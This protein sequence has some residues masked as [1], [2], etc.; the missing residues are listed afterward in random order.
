MMTI[1]R[2]LVTYLV[3]AYVFSGLLCYLVFLRYFYKHGKSSEF[4]LKVLLNLWIVGLWPM[5]IMRE[6]FQHTTNTDTA[7][8][9]LATGSLRP[10]PDRITR[11]GKGSRS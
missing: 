4:N 3:I 6:T 2:V 7:Q 10:E 9:S 1:V 11:N 8:E 5:W